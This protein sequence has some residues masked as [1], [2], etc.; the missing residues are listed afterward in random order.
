MA[1]RMVQLQMTLSELEGHFCC[2]VWQHTSR[3]PSA[4]AELLVIYS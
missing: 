1:Y 4:T 3:G 2:Y